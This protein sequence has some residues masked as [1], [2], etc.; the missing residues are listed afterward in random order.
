MQLPKWGVSPRQLARAGPWGK[1][2]KRGQTERKEIVSVM[3]MIVVWSGW[4]V[5]DR[6]EVAEEEQWRALRLK[7]VG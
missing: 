5:S 2:G 3:W 1:G 6:D 4:A 7:L